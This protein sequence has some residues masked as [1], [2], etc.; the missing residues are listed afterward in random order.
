CFNG[1]LRVSDRLAIGQDDMAVLGFQLRSGHSR[2]SGRRFL[3]SLARNGSRHAKFLIA[4]GYGGRTSRDLHTETT[5]QH[6][7]T[8]PR[9][10]SHDA[11]VDRSEGQAVV[12]DPA[13]EV[14]RIWGTRINA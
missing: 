10:S 11:I 4:V 1:Q 6:L 13:V 8:S 5:A 3:Q 7:A 9:P 14:G 12:H 2:P